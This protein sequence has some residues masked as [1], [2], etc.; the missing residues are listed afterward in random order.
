M[1]EWSA[2]AHRETGAR[3]ANVSREGRQGDDERPPRRGIDDC[4]QRQVVCIMPWPVG[5]AGHGT[6]I[7]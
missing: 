1:N 5:A 7:A 2:I 3:A 4:R 6:S